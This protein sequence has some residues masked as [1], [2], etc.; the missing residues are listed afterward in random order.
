[1]GGRVRPRGRVRE[2]PWGAQSRGAWAVGW[3]G[4]VGPGGQ[5]WMSAG[6]LADIAMSLPKRQPYVRELA[7]QVFVQLRAIR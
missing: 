4:R 3:L 7:C 6:Q 5:A 1:M 2:E